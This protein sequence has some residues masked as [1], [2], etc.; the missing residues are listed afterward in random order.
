MSRTTYDLVLLLML[1]LDKERP[2]LKQGEMAMI[3]M[4]LFV[5]RYRGKKEMEKFVFFQAKIIES[6]AIFMISNSF[7][8]PL[9]AEDVFRGQTAATW[10]IITSFDFY[11]SEGD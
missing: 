2:S 10:D 3:S 6:D 9:E 7:D 4:K 1:S 11:L 8:R 5:E